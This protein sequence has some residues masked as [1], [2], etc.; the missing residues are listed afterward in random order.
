MF[1]YVLKYT[2][3]LPILAQFYGLKNL[4]LYMGY[5]GIKTYQIHHEH[6]SLVFGFV[7]QYWNKFVGPFSDRQVVLFLLALQVEE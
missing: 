2:P 6:E 1:S 5:Y 3:I 4:G 7:S